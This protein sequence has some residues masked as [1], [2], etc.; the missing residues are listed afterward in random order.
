TVITQVTRG[1][2]GGVIDLLSVRLPV[3]GGV[4]AV[5]LPG[6]GDELHRSDGSVVHTVTIAHT[7]VGA[8]DLPHPSGAVQGDTRDRGGRR[9]V[10]AEYRPTVTT[11][12][13]L[14][15]TDARYR[16]P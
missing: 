14:D 11:M 1:G 12:I 2:Q 13:G 8:P 3:A 9:P 4:H 6:G 10:V 7:A 16:D 5:E 15:P